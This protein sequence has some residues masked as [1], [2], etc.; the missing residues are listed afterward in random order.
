VDLKA[1]AGTTVGVT[2]YNPLT[3]QYRDQGTTSGGAVRSF[4]SPFET[5]QSALVLMVQ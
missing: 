5:S 4:V 1:L 2:W 3:G